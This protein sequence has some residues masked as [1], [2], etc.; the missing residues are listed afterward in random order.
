LF[1]LEL[2]IDEGGSIIGE[3]LITDYSYHNHHKDFYPKITAVIGLL[4]LVLE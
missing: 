3:S 2:E 4:Y 1:V